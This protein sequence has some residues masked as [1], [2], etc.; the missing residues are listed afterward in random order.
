MRMGLTGFLQIEVMLFGYTACQKEQPMNKER[1]MM[2]V[3]WF[4]RGWTKLCMVTQVMG[5]RQRLG[6]IVFESK[7]LE[8]GPKMHPQ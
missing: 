6:Q 4:V 1:N 3:V 8:M 5:H 7:D 2:S